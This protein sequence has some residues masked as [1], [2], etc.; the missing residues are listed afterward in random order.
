MT[1]LHGF[2]QSRRMWD[3]VLAALPSRWLLLTPDLRGHGETEVEPGGQYTMDACLEDLEGLWSRLRIERTHLVGYSMGGRVALHV[4]ARRPER[5]L[6]LVTVSAR[7]GL[8]ERERPARRLADEELAATIERNGIEWFVDH[9]S[10]LPMFAGL[11][12]RG[13]AFEAALRERRLRNRPDQLA[14][15]L[16]GMGSGVAPNVDAELRR[17]GR[18]A[19]FI[20][21]A[22]DVTYA[23]AAFELAELIGGRVEIL[24]GTGHN[25]PAERPVELAGLIEAHLSAL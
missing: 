13:A 19:L 9:W 7:G 3:E 12:R 11:G 15:S 16:R 17:F 14:A 4:A 8:P 2:S 25:V 22:D 5:L 23:R 18:P 21:G 20:A 1:F 6:S 10:A 24:P